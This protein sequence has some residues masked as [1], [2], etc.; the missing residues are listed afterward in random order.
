MA[1]TA[2]D[3]ARWLEAHGDALYAY[4]Y[5]RLRTPALAED[6]VQETLLAALGTESRFRGESSERTWLIGILKHKVLD[7]FRRAA[8]ER[9]L[10]EHYDEDTGHIA[11][12]FDESGHWAHELGSWVEP[13]RALEQE[14]FRAA[15]SAC[16]ERLPERLRTLY[17]LREL[18]G[19]ETDELMKIL[20]ISSRN[21]LW[22]MLSR[23]RL[24]LRQCLESN[25]FKPA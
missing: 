13:E 4:A 22:V 14:Q 1:A 6:M 16:L 9:P 20:N 15:L 11:G 24:Q 18:D 2:S 19:L 21:N 23:A 8:R 25:W 12:Y 5:T 3:P 7:H 10:G 17:A